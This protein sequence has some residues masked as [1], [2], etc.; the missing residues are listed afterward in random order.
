VNLN[1]H[2]SVTR[3]SGNLINQLGPHSEPAKNEWDFVYVLMR[4]DAQNLTSMGLLRREN[5]TRSGEH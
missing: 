5:N 1:G 2:S 3:K 4:S